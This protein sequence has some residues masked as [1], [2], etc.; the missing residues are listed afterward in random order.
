MSDISIIIDILT[1][2]GLLICS[3]FFSG[4]ETGLTAASHGQIYKILMEGDLRAQKVLNLREKKEAV[5][6]TILIGNNMVN[7][8]ATAISTSLAIKLFGDEGVVFATIALTAIILI[9][10]EILPKTFAIRNAESVAVK[11]ASI[12]TFL[13]RIFAPINAGIQWIIRVGL[14]CVGVDIDNNSS[15]ISATD[16]IR[17]TIELHHQDGEVIKQERD[18][19]GSILDLS[20][21]E[22]GEVMVHRK[23]VVMIDISQSAH[24]ILKQIVQSGHSRIPFFEDNP[25]N[26]I[27]VL[28]VKDVLPLVFSQQ[29]KVS[30]EDIRSLLVS[31]WFVPEH[32]TLNQQLHDFRIKKRHFALVVDEYGTCQ[33]IITLEDILEE[34]VGDIVDEHDEAAAGLNVQKIDDNTYR[35]KGSVT[36]RDLNRHLDW[37]LPDD[38]ASTVAGLVI[39]QAR[40][41]PEVNARFEFF[42]Y[43]FIIEEKQANQILQLVIEK[44]NVEPNDA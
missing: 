38:D 29:K 27:G 20:E 19:L 11:T 42:G 28:H 3:G 2:V 8:A 37:N 41:I 44:I 1:I 17:G 34:I 32:T 15:L 16:A 13:I 7:I 35:V 30:V 25:E 18:M 33:G 10:S 5:I 26:I 12:L 22:V 21:V 40:S 39:Y 23:Q 36:I 43:H 14:K 6:G 24:D 9:F 31:S 4:A